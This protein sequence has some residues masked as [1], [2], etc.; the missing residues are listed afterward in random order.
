MQAAFEPE[1]VEL[2]EVA[3]GAEDAGGIC[4]AGVDDGFWMESVSL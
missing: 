1:P 3:G 4:A 2:Y